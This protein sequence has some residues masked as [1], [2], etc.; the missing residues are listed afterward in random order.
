[1]WDGAS[2]KCLRI[3]QHPDIPCVAWHPSR[4]SFCLT[5]CCDSKLRVWDLSLD[6]RSST[7]SRVGLGLGSE[8]IC[9]SENP[10][11]ELCKVVDWTSTPSPVTAVTYSL[12][13]DM[14]VAGLFNGL[15]IFFTTKTTTNLNSVCFFYITFFFFYQICFSTE[16]CT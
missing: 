4:P 13:G 1:M 3:L 9:G 16:F 5:G 12:D 7:E 8:K 6:L 15:C 14:V 2:E 11:K 10:R